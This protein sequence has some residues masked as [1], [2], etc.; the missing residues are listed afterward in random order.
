[1]N[2]SGADDDYSVLDH[3]GSLKEL[4]IASTDAYFKK[5]AKLPLEAAGAL[6]RISQFVKTHCISLENFWKASR[7]HAN[8]NDIR[9][10]C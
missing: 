6:E 5:G 2:F 9:E 3:Q 8:I 10:F 1:M 7:N 4:G